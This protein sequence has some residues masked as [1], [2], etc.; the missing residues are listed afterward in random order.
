MSRRSFAVIALSLA[1]VLIGINSQAGCLFWL[2][3]MLLAA[4]SV[5]WLLSLFQV[6]GLTFERRHKQEIGE[7]QLLELTLSIQNRSRIPRSLLEVLDGDPS[8]PGEKKPRLKPPR[9]TIREQWHDPSAAVK[10][11]PEEAGGQAAFLLENMPG[12]TK[13][14]LMYKRGSLRRGVFNDWPGFF[15]SEGILGLTR[16]SSRVSPASRLVVFPSYASLKSFPFID[17]LLHPH[18]TPHGVSAKGAGMDYYGVREFRAGD[19]L[20]HVH[21]RTTARRGELVVREF[22]TEV[23]VPLLILIDTQP[24]TESQGTCDALDSAARLAASIARYAHYAGHPVALASY[25][26][27]SLD[28]LQIPSF[29]GALQWLATVEMDARIGPEEQ[30]EGLGRQI[31]PG[32]FFCH[33]LPAVRFD[34]ARAAAALPPQSHTALVFIDLASHAA[35]GSQISSSAGGSAQIVADLQRAPFPGLFSLSLYRKGD[36]LRECLEKSLITFAGSRF[37]ER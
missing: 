10:P 37:R 3:S 32:S 27:D 19:A 8:R 35:N 18:H 31:R 6:R 36:D 29:R 11:P 34:H 33:I 24:R 5:S 21:W 14:D 20:R 16:H 23:G 9:K 2:A 30:V 25:K 7:D 12:R 22:E 26:G 13:I 17:S 1:L 4:L 28:V 15:Y